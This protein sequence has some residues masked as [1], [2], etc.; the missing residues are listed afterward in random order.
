[1]QHIVHLWNS[2][3]QKVVKVDTIA[4]FEKGLD[5]FIDDESIINY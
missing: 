5:K 1:M 4:K 3:L 2:L